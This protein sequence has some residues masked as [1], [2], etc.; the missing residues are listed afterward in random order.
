M[1]C[2]F[3]DCRRRA[4]GPLCATHT[5]MVGRVHSPVSKS[6]VR[7]VASLV[8]GRDDEWRDRALCADLDTESFYSQDDSYTTTR[9]LC[10]CCPVR[11]ECAAT[12]IRLRDPHGIW[13][14]LSGDERIAVRKMI[15][16]KEAAA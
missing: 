1:R 13:G 14:G 8:T 3:P 7:K 4:D 11:A 15:E 9:I 6:F 10:H 2:S 16:A 5:R 12:A